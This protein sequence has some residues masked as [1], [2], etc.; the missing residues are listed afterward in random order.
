MALRP[1]DRRHASLLS[2]RRRNRLHFDP[3]RAER[4]VRWALADGAQPASHRG[5]WHRGC[6]GCPAVHFPNSVR[7]CCSDGRIMYNRW[8]YVDK[9]AAA[10]QSLWAMYPDGGRAEEI[11]GNNIGT[12]GVF[13]QAKQVPGRDN[14]V[15][16]LGASHAP[17]NMGA[18]LLIDRHKNKR[19]ETAMTCAHAR[20]RSQRQLGPAPVPQR[21]LD[22]GHL[23][24]VVLRPVPAL[25]PGRRAG[26][27]QVLPGLLQ[28]GRHVERPGRV[29]G[30]ISW[31][32]SATACRST[33]IRR[34]PAGKLDRWNRGGCRW[35][36]RRVASGESTSARVSDQVASEQKSPRQPPSPRHRGCG[37]ARRPASLFPT[38]TKGSTELP[39]AR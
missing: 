22:D 19:S 4:V 27:R 31:T 11:Y 38:C 24:A 20:L 14:L 28:S 21:T 18:I 36:W 26:R 34:P 30:F 23:W 32:C 13:S 6:A 3:Q 5:R 1:L 35:C 29:M 12:P 7:R 16:C 37:Q 10:V 25:G 17:G 8:E 39:R 2:P 9:G 15:V 33:G